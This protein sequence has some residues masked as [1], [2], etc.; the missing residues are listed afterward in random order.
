MNS[1]KKIAWFIIGFIFLFNIIEFIS[2]FSYAYDSEESTGFNDYARITDIDYKAVLVDEPG[3][4]GKVVITERLTY[5]I[6]AASQDNLFWELWRDLPEDEVDGLKV[7]YKVN[8][9]KQI[10]GDGSVINYTES[11]KLYWDDSDYVS[12]PYGPYKWYHSGGPYSEYFRRY[13]CV[14]FYVNGLYRGDVTFEI[15]YEMNNAALKYSDVSELYL[16]M[17]SEDTIKYLDSF[18]GQ[19]LIAND[20][21]PKKGN[22]LAHTYGTNNYTFDYTESDTLNPGYHTF[23]FDLD[24]NDL[25]FKSYNQYIEFSLLAFNE[26]R[27]IFTDYAPDNYYSDDVYLEEAMAAINE[28]DQM[29]INARDN[30]I[31]VLAVAIGGSILILFF[32]FRRDK[33]IKKQHNF[34]KPTQEMQYFRDIPSDLDP[35][36]ASELVFIKHKNRIDMGN[37]YSALLLNLVRKGYIELQR[38]DNTKDWVFDNILIRILYEPVNIRDIID[39]KFEL[40]NNEANTTSNINNLQDT[41]NVSNNSEVNTSSLNNNIASIQNNATVVKTPKILD[42]QVNSETNSNITEVEPQR[43]NINGKELEKLSENEE[44]YFNLIVKHAIVDTI[45]MKAF[46]NSV[47]ADYDNT[48]SFMTSINNSVVNIGISQGY[49]QKADFKGLKTRTNS[50]ANCYLWLGLII[51]II[52]NLIISMTRLDLAYGALFILGIVMIIC[53][54]YLKRMRHKYV[55]LTQYGEDEYAKWRG[56]YNFLNSATLM[57]EKTVI[58]LPLWEKYLVYATAFG[59]SDKVIKALKIRCPD[60]SDSVILSNNYYL[61]HNFRSYGRSFRSTTHRASS[62]SRSIRSSGGTFYGGGGRGG[63]GGGGGH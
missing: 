42:N 14:F 50:L 54:I 55:L 31:K 47:Y 52:G 53:G 46:Q 49:F 41:S 57:N 32:V 60:V 17:Y 23:S 48:D 8:Y 36:F 39:K 34:Y 44:A 35:H 21:M 61:S 25:K 30:K 38:V 16:T 37:S 3:E 9:V 5:D 22:Y 10:N 45:T 63:G 7:D 62:M 26:D 1:S 58:E 29:K 13:E 51:L 6:H 56:L 33:K 59:I 43:Y 18:K 28:Y 12:S 2:D 19:I 40:K 24:K 27:H 20:D 15:Q 11:P 4:G